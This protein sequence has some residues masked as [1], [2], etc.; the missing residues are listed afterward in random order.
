MRE[1]GVFYT[2]KTNNEA[3]DKKKNLAQ[4]ITTDHLIEKFFS[5]PNSIQW[6]WF[7]FGFF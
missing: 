7:G 5:S 6:S 4:I 1:K 2:S 3:R